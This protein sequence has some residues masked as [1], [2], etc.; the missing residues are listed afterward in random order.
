[1]ATHLPLHS[2]C[3]VCDY[4]IEGFFAAILLLKLTSRVQ[5]TILTMARILRLAITE[6][7]CKIN[8][9]SKLNQTGSLAGCFIQQ[10]RVIYWCYV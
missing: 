7:S 3:R 5:K 1:M 6:G 9:R 8:I 2:S 4:N 10:H